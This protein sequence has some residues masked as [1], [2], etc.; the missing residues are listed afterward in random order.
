MMVQIPIGLRVVLAVGLLVSDLGQRL[1]AYSPESPEVVEMVDRAMAGLSRLIDTSG[2]HGIGVIPL[3]ALPFV[4]ADDR[5][6]PHVKTAIGVAR[7]FATPGGG[8]GRDGHAPTYARAVSLI[9][10]TEL[11]PVQYKPEIETLVKMLQESQLVIGGWTYPG[12]PNGDS[13]QTQYAVLGLWT[14]QKAGFDVSLECGEKAVNWFMRTQDAQ[15]GFG[16]HPMDPGTFNR[17]SQGSVSIGL[18]AAGTASLY[19]GGDLV[20]LGQGEKQRVKEDD[21]PPALRLIKDDAE[22]KT[23]VKRVARNVNRELLKRYQQDGNRYF[24]AVYKINP[25]MWNYY[26]LYTLERYMSFREAVEGGGVAEPRWYNEG[27]EY[28]RQNQLKDGTWHGTGGAG[29]GGD[30]AFAIMFLT[31]STKKKIEKLVP[32]EGLLSGG[33]NFNGDMTKAKLRDDGKIVAVPKTNA[34]E[35]LLNALEDSKNSDVE[36]IAASVDY[37]ALDFKNPTKLQ[38][39]VARLRRLVSVEKFEVRIVA[40]RTL[41]KTDD[42]DNIPYLI[43]ALTDPDPK[44]AYAADLGLKHITRKLDGVGMAKDPNPQQRL[45]AAQAWKQW[46]KAVNPSAIFLD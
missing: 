3:L 33:K 28:L 1:Q 13:S 46:Y 30:T 5:D 24:D 18:S 31:R 2:E 44:I 19:I 8:Q 9:F 40:V 29:I 26:Y 32:G 38:A 22:E 10:L 14:A 17:N 21:I 15:G 39:Q 6:H 12:M 20:G 23:A 36:G 43:Y 4:K 11:D 41:G 7:Q 16:Y 45:V 34:V 42:F 37:L 25:G 27:V 35:D